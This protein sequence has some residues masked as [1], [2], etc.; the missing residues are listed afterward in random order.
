MQLFGHFLLLLVV[1]L[2]DEAANVD[3][4]LEGFGTTFA[5]RDC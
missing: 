5:C 2:I 4:V 3:S 1:D